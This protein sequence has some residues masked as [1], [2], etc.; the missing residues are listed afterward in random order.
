MS[1]LDENRQRCDLHGKG[2]V[3]IG[4][5]SGIGAAAV[6][7]LAAH[8]ASVTIADLPGPAAGEL[9]ESLAAAGAQTRAASVD[10]TDRA[11][12]DELLDGLERVDVL[13]CTP[14]VNVRKPLLDYR[15]RKRV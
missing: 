14:A 2:A 13:V 4:A 7:G 6:K 15:D 10:L 5:A 3:A 1:E 8:G 9:A 12:V 11:S